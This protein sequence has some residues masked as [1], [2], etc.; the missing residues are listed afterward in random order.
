MS[1]KTKKAN[2]KIASTSLHTFLGNIAPDPDVLY[3]S[4]DVMPLLGLSNFAQLGVKSLLITLP[5][6]LTKKVKR[7]TRPIKT[8][9][10]DKK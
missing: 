7:S 3:I 8:P 1:L 9:P 6:H 10:K 5:V 4:I 2:G